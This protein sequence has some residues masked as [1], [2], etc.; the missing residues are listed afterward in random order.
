MLSLQFSRAL[1]TTKSGLNLLLI[2]AHCD[3]IEIGCGGTILRL[4]HEYPISHVT[5]V[6]FTSNTERKIEARKCAEAFL[7]GVPS[8]EIVVKDFKDGFLSQNYGDVKDFH[9]IIKKEFNPD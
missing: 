8:R 4:I 5:W 2:G 7:E 3:D 9:E 1:G 6:V